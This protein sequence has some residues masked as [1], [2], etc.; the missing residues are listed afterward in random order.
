[1]VSKFGII[2][3]NFGQNQLSFDTL[4]TANEF[5]RMSNKVDVTLFYET[6]VP[7]RQMPLTGL[8]NIYE[9]WGYDGVLIATSVSSAFK[10]L[11][12]P[13]PNQRYFYVY[14]PEW[15]HNPTIYEAYYQLAQS[16]IEFIA[17]TK[18]HADLLKN[19]FNKQPKFILEQMNVEALWQALNS[20][21]RS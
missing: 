7:M 4:Q 17:R 12:M 16:D 21:Q 8:M 3:N 13:N 15:V 1:M 10:V 11:G 20:L 19:N 18:E 5:L 14:N 9:A 6:P 2:V